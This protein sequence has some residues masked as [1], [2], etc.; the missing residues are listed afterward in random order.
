M[1][2]R[3]HL[4]GGDHA[5]AVRLLRQALVIC[6][7][8]GMRFCGPKVYGALARTVTDRD[9]RDR[10]LAEGDALLRQGAVGHN[11]LWFYR[12]AIEAMLA[13]GDAPGAL[14]S[15]PGSKTIRGPR[16]CPG[17]SS[18]LRAVGPLPARC[19]IAAIAGCAASSR[20]SARP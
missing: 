11:H 2:A 16:S 14:N 12:D 13:A 7:D 9:E 3:L 20:A 1:R 17:P 15:P 6:G 4:D 10:W 8:V 5:E 19:G 18:S